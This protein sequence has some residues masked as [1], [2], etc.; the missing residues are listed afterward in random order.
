MDRTFDFNGCPKTKINAAVAEIAARTF[1]TDSCFDKATG[2]GNKAV[3]DWPTIELNY[4]FGSDIS[5]LSFDNASYLGGTIG[6]GD[7]AIMGHAS[8]AEGR[9][10]QVYRT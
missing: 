9:R 5:G 10:C 3:A 2:K 1:D 8:A 6:K 4:I 7:K